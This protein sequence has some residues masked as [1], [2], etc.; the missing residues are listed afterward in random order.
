V[1]PDEI[2]EGAAAL[3]AAQDGGTSI[4]ALAHPPAD[5][6]EAYAIQE[7]ALAMRGDPPAGW[8][9]G[10]TSAAAMATLRTDR[11]FA[12]PV[13][14]GHLLDSTAELTR[15]EL[16]AAMVEGEFAFVMS[17][18]LGPR[19]EPYRRDE[20]AAAVA[21]L[22]PAIEV[23]ANRYEA[24]LAAGILNNIADNGAN[25][26]LVVGTPVGEWRQV[27]LAACDVS[28]TIGGEIVGRGS[29]ADVMGHP[30]ESLVWLANHLRERGTTL[31]A[32]QA[33]TTGSCT[34][35][36]PLPPGTVAVADFGELG[37]VEVVYSAE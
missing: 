13:L 11:P 16:P 1:N 31:R 18:D 14:A 4:R 15:S 5:H 28:M 36:A 24:G 33:V 17:A 34:G 2:E 7:A 20:V 25:S 12:G 6:D 29:G 32:G 26:R 27:D 35:I 8:K 21:E 19:D 30:L 22:R 3:V 9:V 23:V 10:A 37:T